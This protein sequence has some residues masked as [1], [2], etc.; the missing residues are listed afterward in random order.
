MSQLL[1]KGKCIVE[2]HE[3]D[4]EKSKSRLICEK[5]QRDDGSYDYI[6]EGIVASAD[7]NNDNGNGRRY[8]PED[9]KI[10]VERYKTNFVD[11]KI[12]WGEIEHPTSAMINM[13]RIG[14]LVD[15]I[16]MEGNDVHA[17]IKLLDLPIT[18]VIK[19]MIRLGSPI[20]ISSRVVGDLT[21]YGDYI[22]VTGIDIVGFDLVAQPSAEKAWLNGVLVEKEYVVTEGLIMESKDYYNREVIEKEIRETKIKEKLNLSYL[23][24]LSDYL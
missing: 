21:D 6:L 19:E 7:L 23:N 5:K 2:A 9:M 22:L 3:K 13:D 1:M 16:W 14:L 18:K 4:L 11:K 17:K 8:D 12:A 24:K 15:D 20:G 10:A